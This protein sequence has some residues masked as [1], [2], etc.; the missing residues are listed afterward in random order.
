MK[1]TSLFSITIAF[2]SVVTGAVLTNT[3]SVVPKSL[4]TYLDCPIGDIICKNEMKNKCLESKAFDICKNGESGNLEE[5]LADSGIDIEDNTVTEF[6]KIQTQVCNMIENY[7]PPLT[8]DY[9]F[10]VDN[11]LTCKKNDTKCKSSKTATC[12]LVVKMCWGNYPK[13]ACRELSETC[14]KIDLEESVKTKTPTT[15]IKT[16]TKKIAA[17]KTN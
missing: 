2:T 1:F 6:C 3:G 4:L 10:D 12:R 13:D 17:K 7:N 11:Y 14:D 5:L 9:I 16:T 8:K 15:I